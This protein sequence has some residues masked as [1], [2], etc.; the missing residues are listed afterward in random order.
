MK[1]YTSVIPILAS[2]ILL[3]LAGR[4]NM[5]TDNLT[6]AQSEILG[7]APMKLSCS[8][9]TVS[10]GY[11]LP[12]FRVISSNTVAISSNYIGGTCSS[13]DWDCNNP[14]GD[15]GEDGTK[16]GFDPCTIICDYS[17]DWIYCD[18]CGADDLCTE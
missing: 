2:L 13:Y 18:G 4:T 10:L 12:L 1:I 9:K 17:R 16:S 6:N 11:V 14:Y 8:E 7:K 5:E 15:C 3:G